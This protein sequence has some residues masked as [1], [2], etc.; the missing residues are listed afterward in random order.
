MV[1]DSGA[2]SKTEEADCRE[3]Q[4]FAPQCLERCAEVVKMTQEEMNELARA[5]AKLIRT[6]PEVRQAVM[7]CAC[8]CPNLVVQ[9]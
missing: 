3:N 1:S 9:Y 6:N 7:D 8:S 5:L 2:R 4:P